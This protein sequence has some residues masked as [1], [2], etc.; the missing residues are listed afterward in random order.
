MILKNPLIE[1]IQD[2][3]PFDGFTKDGIGFL[4][5]LKKNNNRDWFNLHKQDYGVDIKLP[6]QSLIHDLKPLIQKF[7]PDFVVDPKR[8]LFRIYRDTR[9]SNNKTPYKTHIAAIFQPTKNWKDS[10]GLYLHIEPDEIYLGGGMYM[11][12]N[13]DLKKIRS[14]IANYPNKFLS[15]IESKKFKSFFKTIQGDK[16]KR[17]PPGFSQ[18]D[19][20]KEW[21][22]MKQFFISYSMK[23]EECYKKTFP[24]VSANIFEIMMPLVSFIN[25]A[26]Q[27][28]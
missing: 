12:S 5:Q 24:S 15:I 3:P 19:N 9:F 20:M 8:S 6:M 11:P 17:V 2:Y 25:E 10:A 26:L 13:D 27:T 14:T 4:K 22:K 23:E 16:L 18:N 21:L 1:D 28:E 7:A